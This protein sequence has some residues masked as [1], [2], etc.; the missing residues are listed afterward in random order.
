MKSKKNIKK[1][2][3]EKPKPEKAVSSEDKVEG[4]R[5]FLKKL[6]IGLGLLAGAEFI[7]V[8]SG[9]LFSGKGNTKKQNLKN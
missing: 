4:R 6:W 9:F 2:N 3:P 1:K 5:N 7:A 8:V